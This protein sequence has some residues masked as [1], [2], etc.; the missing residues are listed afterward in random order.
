MDV[1]VLTPEIAPRS[2]EKTLFF[3]YFGDSM[4]AYA[5]MAF[6]GLSPAVGG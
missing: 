1:N 2:S 4:T 5:G 3:E 6:F